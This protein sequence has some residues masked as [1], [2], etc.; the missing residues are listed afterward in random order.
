MIKQLSLS[1]SL[2]FCLFLSCQSIASSA[3]SPHFTVL[4]LGTSGGELEDNLSSYLVAAF[5]TQDFVA[6]DAGTVC[7]AIKKI[8]PAIYAKIGIKAAAGDSLAS[9]LF[10]QHIKA[11]LI[12]H[13]HLDHINGLVMCSVI[14]SHKDIIATDST[15]D[16]LRDDIF[17]WKIWPNLADEG[18]SPQLKQY[19]YRRLNFAT[20]YAL[21]GVQMTAQAFLLNHGNGYPSTAFLLESKGYYLL[22]LGDTGADS[23]EHSQD[24][25]NVWQVVAPFIRE[26]KLTAIFIEASYLNNRPDKL[27]FGH[28]RPDLLLTELNALAKIVNSQQPATALDGLTIVVTHIKQGLE[29]QNIYKESVKQLNAGNHLGVKFIIPQSGQ[30]IIF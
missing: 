12:S 21:P 29:D 9:T 2:I 23:I 4:P 10:A 13:A 5:G 7:T 3:P 15:I 8:Q 17:N 6:L 19:H 24:I 22:Y 26:H 14:D 27:L 25:L 1:I 20:A 28:L 18:K 11:Y 30:L 16:N